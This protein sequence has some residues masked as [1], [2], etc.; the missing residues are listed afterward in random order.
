MQI[1]FAKRLDGPKRTR[2]D[3]I[4]VDHKTHKEAAIFYYPLE[5]SKVNICAAS[6]TRYF[7]KQV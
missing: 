7:G 5:W 4:I 2:S 1:V 6:V 3:Q